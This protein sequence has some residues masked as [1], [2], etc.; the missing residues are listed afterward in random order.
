MD[1]NL[2]SEKNN[3]NNQD[4]QMGQVTLQNDHGLGATIKKIHNT[5]YR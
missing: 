1:K 3:E 2:K 4:S 5:L